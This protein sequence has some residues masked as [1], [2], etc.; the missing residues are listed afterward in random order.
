M[1]QNLSEFVVFI[2]IFIYL[3]FLGILKKSNAADSLVDWPKLG[4]TVEAIVF[5]HQT[6]LRITMTTTEKK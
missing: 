1:M 4:S 6:A 3:L 5:W 2:D